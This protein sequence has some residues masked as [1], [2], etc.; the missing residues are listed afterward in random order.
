MSHLQHQVKLAVILPLLTGAQKYRVLDTEQPGPKAHLGLG[1]GGWGSQ[2]ESGLT[3]LGIED[4]G[5]RQAG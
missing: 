2:E 1:G 3:V 4:P 5:V